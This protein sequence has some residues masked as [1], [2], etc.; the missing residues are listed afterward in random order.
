MNCLNWMLIITPKA[1]ME[2]KVAIELPIE[3]YSGINNND[4]IKN[5]IT[6]MLIA[7]KYYLGCLYTIA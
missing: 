5:V 4:I 1:K 2:N 6:E 7:V 3:K